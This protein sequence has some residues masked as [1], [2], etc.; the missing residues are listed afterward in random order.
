MSNEV[1]EDPSHN[2]IVDNNIIS[3][4]ESD[5]HRSQFAGEHDDQHHRTSPP[6]VICSEIVLCLYEALAFLD[7][8]HIDYEKLSIP[9]LGEGRPIGEYNP[10]I[11]WILE[12]YKNFINNSSERVRCALAYIHNY[13]FDGDNKIVHLEKTRNPPPS[14]RPQ[15]Q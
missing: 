14:S 8:S 12:G 6:P 10:A 13:N 7:L 2:N 11:V 15:P 4:V 5:E 1:V 9:I 3:Q